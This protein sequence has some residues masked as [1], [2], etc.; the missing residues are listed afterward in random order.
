MIKS[1]ERP[2]SSEIRHG[3]RASTWIPGGIAIL[4]LI[5]AF[6]LQQYPEVL[7]SFSSKMSSFSD[8][9]FTFTV[10]WYDQT[11]DKD[12]KFKLTFFPRDNS[13]EMFDIKHQRVFLKRIVCD[14]LHVGDFFV[15]NHVVVLARRLQVLEYGDERTKHALEPNHEATFAMVKPDGLKN[16]GGIL[17]LIEN[18][19]FV[20][21]DAKMT[22]LSREHAALFYQEHDRRSFF[23]EL[24]EY[25]TS[26][27]VVALELMRSNAVS[28]WRKLLGP[29]DA[30]K[31]IQDA[32]HSVRAKFGTDKTNNAAHGSDSPEAAARELNFFFGNDQNKSD[33][34]AF[35]QSW[36]KLE[37]TTCCMVLAIGYGG[38]GSEDEE[39]SQKF[40]DLV[41]PADPDL[42]KTIRP[43]SL[44]AKYGR[45]K[46]ENGVHCSDLPEDA[47]LEVEYFFKILQ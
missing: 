13:V 21:S 25:I 12:R 17:E 36:A 22:L 41:G 47:K 16:L 19:G 46:D 3:V 34:G 4:T 44:R 28:E 26:G 32:P 10:N 29:T 23:G 30:A 11:M 18:E 33:R 42:A 8:D 39:A 24:L 5:T 43:K 40:R 31:A 37:N 38:S 15:G 14:G 45:T 7:Q 2:H 6:L 27:P 20:V 9:S 35:P 1:K